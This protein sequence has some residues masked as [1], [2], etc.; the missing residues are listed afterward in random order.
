MTMN[1]D[2]KSSTPPIDASDVI[3]VQ[4]KL[5]QTRLRKLWSRVQYGYAWLQPF[6]RR[7]SERV[8]DFIERISPQVSSELAQQNGLHDLD[9]PLRARWVMRVIIFGLI[10]LF[11]WAAIGQIDQVTR[12]QA[13]LIAADRTQL[14]QSSDGGVL[15]ELHVKEGQ[16]VKAGQLLATL[17]KD[18][19]AAAVS[20]SRA[21]VAALRITLARLHAEVY[22]KALEF[23]PDLLQYTEYIRNQTALYT[24][25]QTAF[26]DDIRALENIL[27]LVEDEL[28]INRQLEGTGDVSRAEVLRL[29][30]SVADVKAQLAGKRNKYFQ[31]AQTEMTKAQEDL[32][33]QN[34]QLK[35]RSQV[36]EHTELI[37]PMDAVVNSVKVTT[38]GGVVKPGETVLELLPTGHELIA[39]AKIPPADMAFLALGQDASIKIDAYDSSIFGSLRG[40]VDYISADAMFAEKASPGMPI[41]PN[42]PPIYYIVRIRITANEF[43]GKKANEIKVRPGLTASVEIK[44]LER[45]VLSY[46]VKPIAKT[47][48][49]S[50]G[51]R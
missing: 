5:P 46:L 31:D 11:I 17:Q 12:A 45:S 27:I 23:E 37:A 22:G 3:D 34:E 51:E 29:Q 2:P 32:S 28:R 21:K 6:I 24:K 1:Y 39:E 36:L 19:A 42:N 15:T 40:K 14:V 47:L 4:A 48:S 9:A 35:D 20:D 43:H 49:E 41:G 18:R 50:L 8:G 25:R 44:A 33:S 30:R 10:V 7:A 13:V 26:K 16:T 38:I